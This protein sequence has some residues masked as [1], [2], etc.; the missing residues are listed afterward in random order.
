MPLDKRLK[1]VLRRTLSPLRRDRPAILGFRCRSLFKNEREAQAGVLPPW[2]GITLDRMREFIEIFLSAGYRFISPEENLEKLHPEAKYACITFDGG[3]ANNLRMKPLLD[4]YHI[5]A[6]F[7]I[8]TGNVQSGESFWWDVLYRERTRRGLSSLKIFQEHQML[9][10]KHH[11]D[12][13]TYLQDIFG[14]NCMVSWSDSD[15]PMTIAELQEYATNPNVYI[16][17]HTHNHYLLDHYSYTEVL[18]QIQLAQDHIHEW[19]GCR[20]FSMAY[21]DG[22]YSN[23]VICAARESGLKRGLTMDE[24]KT[25]IPPVDDFRLGRFTLRDNTKMHSQCNEFRSDL[26]L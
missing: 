23:L 15:R 13:I 16:G 18:E 26:F 22:R 5:S 20:P 7:Y 6:T 3:Y 9:K 4:E 24:H 14:H 17:N 8:T 12:I 10:E 19:L 1:Q 21:P 25:P 11:L 2:D